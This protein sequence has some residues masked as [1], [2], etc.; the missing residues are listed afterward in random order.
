[1]KEVSLLTAFKNKGQSLI[2]VIFALAIILLVVLALVQIVTGAIRSSD[3]AQKSSQ[4]TAYSQRA[5]EE[6]RSFRDKNT[7]AD[8]SIA[9]AAKNFGLTYPDPATTD[10]TLTVVSCADEGSANQKKVVLKVEWT[11]STTTHKSELT[12]YFSNWK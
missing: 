5:M 2:E 9:C 11:D 4:A 1:M 10:F 12:S 6:I 7:W 3:F 8:F